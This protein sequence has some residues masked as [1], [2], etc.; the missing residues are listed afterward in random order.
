M[1]GTLVATLVTAGTLGVT[2][3][4]EP[5]HV[6]GISSLTA[7]YGDSRLSTLVG[8]CFSLGHVVLVIAW[9]TVAYL[10][11]GRT[12][13]PPLYGHLGTLGAG[14]VLGLLG[15]A[16][17]VVGARRVLHTDEHNHGGTSHSHVHPRLP[18]PGVDAHD[19]DHDARSY[20]RTGLV[21]ALFTLS[22]PVSMLVFTAALLP[23]TG[24]GVVTMA[25][26]TYAVAITVTMSLL[27]AGVG[28]AAGALC[29]RG[30]TVHGAAQVATGLLVVT[31]AA[32]LLRDATL[33][34]V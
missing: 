33:A 15:A 7:E 11:L 4:I 5:D 6:A 21:G 27:G 26:G 16:A 25:V 24:A 3:A 30:P 32:L 1:S 10:L 20:L 18:L 12:G 29:E 13:F 19:H 2:H 22:P 31:L 8:A 9:L 23:D 14:L 34:L 17:M 28:A